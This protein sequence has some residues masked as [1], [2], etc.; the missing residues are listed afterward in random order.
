MKIGLFLWSVPQQPKYYGLRFSFFL[1][2]SFCFAVSTVFQAFFVSYLVEPKYE[3]KIETLDELLFSEVL[4][5]YNQAF[6]HTTDTVAYPEIVKFFDQRTQKEECTGSYS[7][8]ERMITKSDVDTISSPL[9]AGYRA[10]ELGI[11]DVGKIV[12]PLMKI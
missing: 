8:V 9:Y 10:R 4:L 5:G 2:V 3:R 12:C 6:L 7:C 11:V 1:Y